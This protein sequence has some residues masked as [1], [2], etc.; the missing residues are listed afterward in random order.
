[1]GAQLTLLQYVKLDWLQNEVLKP[2]PKAV[3]PANGRSTNTITICQI[4]LATKR[5]FETVS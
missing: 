5:S 1:M 3:R 4:G 2:F